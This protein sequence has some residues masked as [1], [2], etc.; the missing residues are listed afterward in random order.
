MNTLS[1]TYKGIVNM[2]VEYKD[3]VI[4]SAYHNSGLDRLFEAVCKALA[5]Y[6]IENERP[7]YLT[8]RGADLTS[9]NYSKSILYSPVSLT[10]IM[11]E[12][13]KTNKSWTTKF[14]GTFSASDVNITASAVKNYK[15]RIYLLNSKPAKN[16]TDNDIAYIDITQDDMMYITAGT[17][18][19][20]EWT[21]LFENKE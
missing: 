20:I 2:T 15:Y 12:Y 10:N 1:L 13:D 8:V 11:Y 14:N 16:T 6:S 9:D 5:G 4:H 7:K 21:M 3:R 19:V 17:R 18:A